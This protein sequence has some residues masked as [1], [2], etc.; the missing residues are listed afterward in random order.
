MTSA[1]KIPPIAQIKTAIEVIAI[2][3][4][5]KTFATIRT[6]TP[7][8]AFIARLEAVFRTLYSTKA[9]TTARINTIISVV[10]TVITHT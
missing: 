3:S 2:S 4:P 6:I 10:P 9:T 7:S 1:P 8:A 5:S